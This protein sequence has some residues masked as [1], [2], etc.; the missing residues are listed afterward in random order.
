MDA[1][2]CHGIARQ[3]RLTRVSGLLRLARNHGEASDAVYDPF[4]G[5]GTTIIAAELA[6]R[7]C[8]AIDI[9]P[10]WVDVCVEKWQNYTQRGEM[11]VLP[12]KFAERIREFINEGN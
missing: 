10:G 2:G 1:A 6:E 9:D 3:S 7:R 5:S 12:D 11:K 4:V 8:F